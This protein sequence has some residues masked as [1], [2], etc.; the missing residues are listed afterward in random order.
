M[1]GGGGSGGGGGGGE[2]G[3]RAGDSVANKVCEGGGWGGQG[4]ERQVS[5]R[6]WTCEDDELLAAT[7]LYP[8]ERLH[9]VVSDADMTSHLRSRVNLV[10]QPGTPDGAMFGAGRSIH[11]GM[12]RDVRFMQVRESER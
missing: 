3:A 10:G 5:E 9:E 11:D 7:Q 6:K 8:L 1:N 12:W 2:S 4:S